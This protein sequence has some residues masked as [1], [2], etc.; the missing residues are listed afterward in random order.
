MTDE[1]INGVRKVYIG[2]LNILILLASKSFKDFISSSMAVHQVSGLP[3]TI[4]IYRKSLNER[5]KT[6]EGKAR[7]KLNKSKL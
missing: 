2:I 3:T 1:G 5:K 7:R 6:K 4:K